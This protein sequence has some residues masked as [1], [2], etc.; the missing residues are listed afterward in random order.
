MDPE[1][2]TESAQPQQQQQ[3]Q[4][5]PASAASTPAPSVCYVEDINFPC[6]NPNCGVHTSA[7]TPAVSR[8][9]SVQNL[10][11]LQSSMRDLEVVDPVVE[12]REDDAH[13]NGGHLRSNLAKEMMERYNN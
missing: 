5:R 2:A 3:T 12:E 4:E 11:G 9:T 10:A 6:N 1:V 7:N 8:T 13:G